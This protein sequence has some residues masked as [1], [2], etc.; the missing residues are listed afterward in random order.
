MSI[1]IRPT[2]LRQ[3]GAPRGATFCVITNAELAGSIV[4]EDTAGYADC[5]ILL[6][7][8]IDDF[9]RLLVEDIPRRAHVLVVSPHVFFQSPRPGILGPERKLLGMACN[10]TPTSPEAIAHFLGVM[11]DTDADA[12]QTFAESFFERGRAAEQLVF[13]DERWGLRAT[14]DHL[15]ESYEWNQQAGPLEWGEQQIS[16]SGELSVLPIEILK[17]NESLSLR[18][19]GDIALCGYPILHSG[20]GP[21]ERSD[22]ARRHGE[23]ATM[24]DYAVIAHV[25]H[26][27][28]T[29][30][31][32][33]GPSA[34]PARRALQA[35]FDSDPRYR[36]LWEVGFAI[37]T[38]LRLLEGNHAMNEVYGNTDGCIHWGFGLTPYTQYHLDVISPGTTVRDADGGWVLG[39]ARPS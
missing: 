37:N 35:M 5:R 9:D 36:I 31:D 32:V 39:G 26:G 8:G 24:R 22:Q 30:L 16:P 23:L 7:N 20:T 10:S 3:L 1:N 25:E 15:D 34:E 17:L 12:Q 13:V 19:D 38:S 21:F 2:R 14:F 29:G 28:V 33:T 4:I 6:A 27:V 18:I 11:E